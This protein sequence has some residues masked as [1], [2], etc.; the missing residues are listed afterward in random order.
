[1]YMY[2][3]WID[4]AW[5]HNKL[6][7]EAE[8]LRSCVIHQAVKKFPTIYGTLRIV[9]VCMRDRRF[10]LSWA[11][12]IQSAPSHLI[13]HW[14]ILIVL[15]FSPVTSKMVPFLQVFRNLPRP[16][17]FQ[18]ANLLITQFSSSS[19]H[20]VPM[21]SKIA[22]CEIPSFTP[23]WNTQG[24]SSIYFNLCSLE[25]KGGGTVRITD[26]QHGVLS[27]DWRL[28]FSGM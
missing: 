1:M 23:I 8:A 11:K 14:F 26:M 21:I 10:F 5:Q 27:I 18:I 20:L 22:Y 19:P 25:S 13:S 6:L 4:K 28:F 24:C 7:P 3:S 15:R 9:T 17:R 16:L 2:H 12:W